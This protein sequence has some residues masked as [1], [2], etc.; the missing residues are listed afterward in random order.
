MK[1]S[2]LF[3]KQVLF[4]QYSPILAVIGGGV[5]A[6]VF[7][8]FLIRWTGEERAGGGWIEKRATAP[9]DP[10]DR[11]NPEYQNIESETALT[12]K[13]QKFVRRQLRERNLMLERRSRADHRFFF[14]LN[15]PGLLQAWADVEKAGGAP[16]EADKA[17]K[18]ELD[19]LAASATPR[20]ETN[21]SVPEG[22]DPEYLGAPT[23]VPEGRGP[24]YLR[25]A[26]SVPEGS[27]LK[28][29]SKED[30]KNTPKTAT[31]NARGSSQLNPIPDL[32]EGEPRKAEILANFESEI[33][34]KDWPWHL[35]PWDGIADSL[36]EAFGRERQIFAAFAQW[37]REQG[38]FQGINAVQI[39]R[40]PYQ[41]KDTI[42][43]MF[44]TTRRSNEASGQRPE[45]D[46]ARRIREW[47]EAK[48][49]QHGPRI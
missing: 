15:V 49:A 12:Y 11:R 29:I 46:L 3:G 35:T 19:R 14:K 34:V 45:S 43:P 23:N 36:V 38:K 25:D 21:P 30:T 47:Q 31:E 32:G 42:W 9:R 40:N 26:D 17:L 13:Q 5:T 41:F 28:G 24:E 2:E 16:S 37:M 6:G 7:L 33:G 4:L 39:R 1:L 18:R 20:E 44:L 48:G 8:A 10:F 27:S 22:S